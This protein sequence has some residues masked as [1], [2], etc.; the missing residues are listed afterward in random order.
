VTNGL[1][2]RPDYAS[3]IPVED[4]WAIAA[5]VKALQVSQYSP[6]SDVPPEKRAALPES[7][8]PIVLT[9][10]VFREMGQGSRNKPVVR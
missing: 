1:G 4:R 8:L 7:A 3:Q 10:P 5:Y 2:A 9:P 6:V